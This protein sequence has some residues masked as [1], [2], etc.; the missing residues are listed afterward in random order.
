MAEDDEN[1]A[2]Y[3]K[4]MLQR[5]GYNP[6]V[7]ADGRAVLETVGRYKPAALVLLDI[8]LPYVDGL[9]LVRTLRA[10]PGWEEVPIVMLSS[11][12]DKQIIDQ[13]MTAGANDY[14]IKPFTSD[15]LLERVRHH[16]PLPR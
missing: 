12:S 4:Y 1:I 9:Q 16:V 10:R 14:L 11:V 8:K 15:A 2:L 13:A 6:V 5:E 3:L 7:L